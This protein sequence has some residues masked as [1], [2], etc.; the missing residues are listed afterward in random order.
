M[1]SDVS[2]YLTVADVM[3]RYGLSSRS[4]V[5]QATKRARDP[6]RSTI[7]ARGKGGK[8]ALL[9]IHA[10]DAEREWGYRLADGFEQGG[11]WPAG[12]KRGG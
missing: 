7:A 8:V 5:V 1:T 10:A 3:A 12:R 9:L 4:S 6:V 11:G 2:E